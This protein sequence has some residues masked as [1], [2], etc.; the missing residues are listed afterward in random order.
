[1]AA[2]REIVGNI[3]DEAAAKERLA[4]NRGG[5]SPSGER[6]S[7]LSDLGLLVVSCER[8]EMRQSPGGL[9]V[10]REDGTEEVP[11][12][13]SRGAVPEIEELFGALE[14]GKPALHGGEWGMATLEVCLAI[15]QSGREHR[16]V[17]LKHQVGVPEG[18]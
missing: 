3:R 8:G 15:M 12:T 4:T 7:Y 16:D 10:Y 2:R 18:Y 1:M 17:S 13:Q 14:Q 5:A 11:L 9:Y 6:S